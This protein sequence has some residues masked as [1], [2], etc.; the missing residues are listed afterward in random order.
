MHEIVNNNN[1]KNN[2]QKSASANLQLI[3]SEDSVTQG[4]CSIKL[5]K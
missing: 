4:N 5:A 1:Q 3:F 2:N